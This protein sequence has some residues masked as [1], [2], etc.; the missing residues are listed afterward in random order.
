MGGLLK[1]S[2]LCGV[3]ALAILF[4]IGGGTSASAQASAESVASDQ[5]PVSGSNEGIEEVIVTAQKRSQNMQKIGISISA[6]SSDQIHDSGLSNAKSLEN[7]VPGVVFDSTAGGTGNANLTLRG[8]SQSDFSPI[9]ESPNSIYIDGV[10]LSSPNEG[11]FALYDLQRIEVLRGPQG[12]LYGNA[13]SGGL[14][15]F[16]TQGPTTDPQGYAQV[17]YSSYNDLAIEAAYGGPI[18]DRIRFRVA[19]H[20]EDAD[21]WFRNLTPG[22]K[23]AF[24]TKVFGVRGQLEVDLTD[25]LTAHFSMSYDKSPHHAEGNYKS[26]PY[27]IGPDGQPAPLPANLDAYGTGPGNDFTGYRSPTNKPRAAAFNNVGLLQNERTSPTFTLDWKRGSVSVTSI[28]NYTNFKFDYNEDCD[29]GPVDFCEFPLAQKLNQWSEELRANGSSGSLDWTAGAYYLNV[30]QNAMISTQLPGL[31]GTPFA[32]EDNNQIKQRQETYAIF[33]QAEY[34][35][36]SQ[37]RALLGLRYT[38]DD[39]TFNSALYFDELGSFYGGSGVYSPP[40]LAYD[41]SPATV[42]DLATKKEGMW[43]G[44]AELDY[45]PDDSTLIYASVSRGVKGAG[46]NANGEGQLT[47]AETPFKSEY[48]YAYELGSK[49]DLLDHRL[50]FNTAA[51]YY[52]YHRFQG[53]AFSGLQAQVGNY[54]GYFAGGE[55]ELDAVLPYAINVNL[56]VSYLQTRLDNVPTTYSGIRDENSIEAP[57]WTVNGLAQKSFEIGGDSLT[58]QWSF[59]YIDSRYSSIDNNPATYVPGSFVH[60]ARISYLWTERDTEFALFVNNISNAKDENFTYDVIA[61]EGSIIKSYGKPRWFGASI[62]KEF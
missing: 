5:K 39:R 1:T 6:I 18:T 57:K 48:L 15:N 28:T 25:S 14:V 36:S 13:S 3:S 19:G 46:F 17:S 34:Q 52:D 4:S 42:G 27:Y 59:N 62:R 8:V 54:D 20:Y 60:N 40:L 11:A 7:V 23:D 33:G 16:I 22:G 58:F 29:G 26:Q 51:F 24:A 56:G 21:G 10:Y 9:Q 61:N 2:S 31:S 32:F 47:A 30:S 12:T 37:F 50:R 45:T 35:L 41:F 49:L 55:A 44:K 38:H 43:S 53:Y